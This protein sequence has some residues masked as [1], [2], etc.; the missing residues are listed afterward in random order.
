MPRFVLA[1]RDADSVI[2][3]YHVI[4]YR[5]DGLRVHPQPCHL[6]QKAG[7]SLQSS[8]THPSLAAFCFPAAGVSCDTAKTRVIRY[9][10]AAIRAFRR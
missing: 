8:G 3:R 10:A 5:Q 7:M 1:V 4:G 6:K 9:P 2:L